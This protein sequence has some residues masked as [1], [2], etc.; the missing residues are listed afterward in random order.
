M[1]QELVEDINMFSIICYQIA[2]NY[3]KE[4]MWDY[5]KLER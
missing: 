2:Q 5:V 1:Q 3:F 4:E